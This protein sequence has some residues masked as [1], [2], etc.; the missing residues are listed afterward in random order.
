ML[1]LINYVTDWH[2]IDGMKPWV[3]QAGVIPKPANYADLKYRPT[4][5]A[6]Y[7]GAKAKKGAKKDEKKAH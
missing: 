6:K 5:W 3:R 1:L 7:K 2:M 4:S